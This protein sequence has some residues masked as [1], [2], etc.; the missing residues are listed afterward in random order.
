MHNI[1]LKIYYGI[2]VLFLGFCYLFS[3]VDSL[4]SYFYISIMYLITLLIGCIMVG[5]FARVF[6]E[7]RFRKALDLDN[8]LIDDLKEG[9]KKKKKAPPP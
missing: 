8:T 7:Y 9:T 1:F 6:F 3:K 5:G 2:F 4:P